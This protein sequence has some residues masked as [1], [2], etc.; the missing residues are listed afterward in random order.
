MTRDIDNLLA[1]HTEDEGQAV[2]YNFYLLKCN[3]DRATS[4][5]VWLAI[6]VGVGFIFGIMFNQ[7]GIG[8]A[9]GVTIGL[10]IGLTIPTTEKKQ[11]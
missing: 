5:G 2:K 8:A 1:C 6:G 10:A 11:R 7:I 3:M 4:I 9:L